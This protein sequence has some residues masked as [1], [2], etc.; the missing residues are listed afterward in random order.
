MVPAAVLL[1]L[2]VS[3]G[4]GIVVSALDGSDVVEDATAADPAM[5]E[6]ITSV[7][8]IELETEPE[9]SPDWCDQPRPW[10]S[11][12]APSEDGNVILTFERQDAGPFGQARIAPFSHRF[13]GDELDRYAL[14]EPAVQASDAP[15]YVL[16]LSVERSTYIPPLECVDDDDGTVRTLWPTDTMA[17]LYE[18]AG[19]QPVAE[20]IFDHEELSCPTVRP[21]VGTDMLAPTSEREAAVMLSE[22][23][24]P[25]TFTLL[26]LERAIN[27]I[28]S[29]PRDWCALPQPIEGLVAPVGV[30][31]PPARIHPTSGDWPEEVL[32]RFG[33]PTPADITHI[34]CVAFNEQFEPRI[35]CEYPGGI[36]FDVVARSFSVTLIPVFDPDPIFNTSVE[37]SMVC[38]ATAGADDDGVDRP[39]TIPPEIAAWL[40]EILTP[41]SL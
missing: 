32:A 24:A 33:A 15:H 4:M 21:A 7:G 10:P 8:G 17:T 22:F 26:D 29:D 39:A 16:C 25:S 9:L 11:A 30:E 23:A 14:P 12:P 20:Y 36:S 19:G 40:D 38:P 27:G 18:L 35:T 6:R 31:P 3:F 1:A 13:Y 37:G 28:G 2:V 41:F 34:A 5:V